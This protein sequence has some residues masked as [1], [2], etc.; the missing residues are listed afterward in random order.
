MVNTWLRCLKKD[1]HKRKIESP[2]II[3]AE[4]ILVPDDN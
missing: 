4:S 3:Y 2:F 1:E